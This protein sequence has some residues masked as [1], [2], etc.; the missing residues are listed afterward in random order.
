VNDEQPSDNTAAAHPARDQ[1]LTARQLAEILQVSESTV[2]RLARDGR[3]PSVRITSRITRFHLQAVRD[4]LDG[5]PRR[6]TRPRRSNTDPR[7][8]DSQLLFKEMMNAE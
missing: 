1:F 7:Q 5:T 4:A 6:P 8:D 3:I 2:R